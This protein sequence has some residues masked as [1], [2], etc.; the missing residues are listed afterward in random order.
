MVILDNTNPKP[1]KE[2]IE[3]NI[4][5][6]KI[7][8]KI[9]ENDKLCTNDK[10]IKI[11]SPSIFQGMTRWI[12]SEGRGVTLERLKEIIDKTLDI[13]EKLL[14]SEKVKKDYNNKDLEENNSQ[15]FQKFIIEMT[16]CLL[17]LENLKKTY[18]EDILIASQIDLLLKKITIRIEKM[19]KLFAIRI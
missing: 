1:N 4:L 17:G 18:G 3:T 14:D 6:L 2:E 5:N 11:D 8:S 13:T 10:I 16:N 15:I 12:N 19:T 7:I 9:K